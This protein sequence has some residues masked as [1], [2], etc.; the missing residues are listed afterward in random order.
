MADY[1]PE[2]LEALLLQL[3]NPDTQ[4]IKQAEEHVKVYLKKITS[5]AGLMTQLQHSARPEVRQ[6]A[7]LL[8]RKKIFKHWPKLDAA[9]QGAVKQTLLSRTVEDP[10]HVVRFN[11]ASL[12]ASLATHEFKTGSWPELMIFI[13]QTASSADENHREVSMKLLQLLGESMGTVLQPHFNDLKQLYATALQ[14]PQSLKV[15]IASMRAA[16]A[17]IEFLEEVDLRQFQ[18]LVPLMI[19]VLQQ[20]VVNGAETE[21]VELLDVL[22]EV[23]NHP[24][25]VLDQAFASFIEMLLQ[26]L[27]HE[28][29]ETRTRASAAYA[30]GEFVKRKP[31]AIGKKNLVGKI[32]TT[33]L[34]I[35][36]KDDRAMCGLISNILDRDTNDSDDDEDDESPGHLAQQTLDTLALSV[37]AKYVNGV[38][39]GVCNEYMQSP[40]PTRRKAG[41][42]ALGILSEGCCEVMCHNIKELIPAAYAA[43]QDADQR[44]RGA[45]V[46]SLGQF[47][48]FLQPSIAEYYSQILPIAI[49]MLD[50]NTKEIKA[51]ALYVVDEITQSMETHEAAPYLDTLVSKLVTVLRT[52][53]PQL[54][55]MCLDALGSIAV[56]A[57]DAFLPYLNAVAELIQPFSSITDPKF[58]FLRGAAM[59]CLGYLAVA[60]G[61]EPFRPYY[62]PSMAFVMASFE[63]DDSELK[64]QAFVFFINLSS[65]YKEEFAPYLDQAATFVLQTLESD[66]GLNVMNDDDLPEGLQSDDEDEE[67]DDDD[68]LL[69][70]ISIRTDALNAKVRAIAAVEEMALNCGQ[71]FEQYIPKFLEALAR[72]TEYI[73]EDV[74]GAVAE[75]L[76][77]LVIC[78]F[79]AAH[80]G[81]TET[82]VWVKGD[83]DKSILTDRN[84]L[85]LDAVVKGLVEEL[86]QD[87][88]EVVV[89]KA[90]NALKIMSGRIGPV[91]TLDYMSLITETVEKILKHEHDCQVGL[92]EDE[93]EGADGG[94]VLEAASELVGVL[95]KC[96]G[97]QFHQTFDAL[98]PLLLAFATG[99]RAERD[100]AAVVGCFAEVLR[101]I[102]AAGLTYVERVFPVVL[103]GLTSENYVLRANSAFCVGILAEISGA[104][105]VGAY[106]QILHALRPL[107]DKESNDD[108]VVD[109]AAAAVARLITT[110][111]AAVPL[112]A[113]MPVF[114]GAL[115]L[116][117]DFD[118]NPIVFKC[119][120]GL[121]QSRNPVVM[122]AMPQVLEV[123]AKS[124]LETS[125]VEEDEQEQI[126]V[127]L[128]GLLAEFDAQVKGVVAQL[129]PELQAALNSAL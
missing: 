79:D 116:T 122:N 27:L 128:R 78:S 31:K 117:A 98:F 6:M 35:I 42:L 5:V 60:L 52:S 125:N 12:I 43:A 32:F 69:H 50:D 49:T 23:A 107:F 18:A 106:E 33:M 24:F 83:F 81:T 91:V 74:R 70:H 54:Q 36:A 90:F 100:R 30:I 102:G 94:S 61:Q 73:H 129:N 47:A 2:Q 115:P 67:V 88:E 51:A 97:E 55:K 99:L 118:E 3:T 101:E 56:G 7:S 38:V 1:A 80:P 85:I 8:L 71:I 48:E 62:A 124:F 58:F 84:K 59:E 96:Y 29:L 15:R 34:D 57:K 28:A 121:V 20:C 21:A 4:Q 16:C 72:L 17:L 40:D 86:I 110:N 44:V 66:E 92:E 75:A 112:E 95:G 109:N 9:T 64:E 41:V 114:L 77:G 104:N 126:K 127:Q 19:E 13:N 22:S 39:F 14:D 65:V 53:S 25:P 46:F 93:E 11:V 111:I 37:P 89:E 87:P 113:V 68:N 76:A 123:Y 120:N 103:Q 26:I 105:L 82:Q 119:L 10:I 63:F 108:V 45:A